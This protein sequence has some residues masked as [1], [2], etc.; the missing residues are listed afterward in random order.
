MT[1]NPIILSEK[2]QFYYDS[3]RDNMLKYVPEGVKKTL[4]LGCGT[5]K[6]SKLVCDKFGAECWGIELNRNAAD[7]AAK[8]LHKV[9]N[10]DIIT[11]LKEIPDSYFDCI[12]LNDI[13]EHLVDPY[14]LLIALKPKLTVRGVMVLSVPNVRY[15]QN[16]LKLVFLG[17]WE[18]EEYGILDNTHL[19]F[20]TYKS[21]RT[22]FT[23]LGFI[24]L[25]LE[26]IEPS[27]T[28]TALAVKLINLALL[29]IFVDTQF[30]QFACV[31]AP[32]VEKPIS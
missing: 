12:I 26:G 24:I 14:S 10:A 15:W 1:I 19:R 4:E 17:Q 9:L 16:F 3:P 25:K 8:V 23:S 21:L 2:P 20:Y 29:N 6:F 13:I 18:Y 7:K 30:V 22:M 32:K 27:H 28:W 31:V 11:C 5:G